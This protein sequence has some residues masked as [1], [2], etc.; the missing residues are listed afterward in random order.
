MASGRIALV[1]GAG[2]GVGKSVA[3]ALMKEGYAVVLAGR[4]KEPLEAT[5]AEGKA[6][7]ARALAVPAN[8]ADPASVKAL[9][10]KTKEAFGRLDCYSTMPGIGAPAV[11]LEDLTYEQ[12]KVSRRHQPDGPFPVHAGSV[13]DH[14]EPGSHAAGASST[15][16][17]SRR[18]RPGR[19]PRPTPRRSTP[20]PA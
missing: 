10:A 13:P 18:M 12:W 20:S 17:R 19:T 2:S 5:A 14:E 16:V 11:P 3:L 8:V 6:I 4:R 15:T 9:F 1:T 7:G